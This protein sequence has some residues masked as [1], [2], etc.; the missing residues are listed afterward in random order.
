MPE[1]I[2]NLI[3]PR[4][5]VFPRHHFR[6]RILQTCE[7]VEATLI[8]IRD[9]GEHLWYEVDRG[10]TITLYPAGYFPGCPVEVRPINNVYRRDTIERDYKDAV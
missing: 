4:N 7:R 6:F 3:F 5:L 8:G 9:D 2:A 10:Q 1:E